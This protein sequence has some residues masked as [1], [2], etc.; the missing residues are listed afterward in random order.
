AQQGLKDPEEA[1][2][3]ASDYLRFFALVAL[4]WMWL[5]MARVATDRLAAGTDEPEFYQAKLA[6]AK[7]YMA[8]ILPQ[9]TALAVAMTSG[10]APIM[11]LPEA[12]Y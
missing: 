3:A 5:R 4:G 6:V 12:A 9:H 7:F 1:G 11:E 8:R 2:A 10:K